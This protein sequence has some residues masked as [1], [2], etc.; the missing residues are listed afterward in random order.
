MT[1]RCRLLFFGIPAMV[2]AALVLFL[3][4]AVLTGSLASPAHASAEQQAVSM[5]DYAVAVTVLQGD[6]LWS[7]AAAADPT[8]DVRHVVREII[9]LNDLGTGVLQAGQRLY[10]P[11][12]K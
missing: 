7:I 8:R 2:A 11:I 6:S 9:A 4:L 10:V 3:A 5:A 1:R 12:P